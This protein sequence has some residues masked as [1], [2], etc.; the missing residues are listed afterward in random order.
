VESQKFAAKFLS[1]TGTPAPR[2]AGSSTPFA[3][4][5]SLRMTVH[6]CYELQTH[7]TR[8][9]S[10]KFIEEQPQILRLTTPELKTFGAPF[11]QDD[12]RCF[13]MNVRGAVIFGCSSLTRVM[14]L[15]MTT[16]YCCELLGH[17]TRCS[18]LSAFRGLWLG[19][20]RLCWGRG[21]PRLPL[22]GVGPLELRG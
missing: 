10:Q 21:Y 1:V 17:N 16:R 14:M 3:S 12:R 4:L 19:S 9:L 8:G 20:R 11:A 5:R 7:D 22:P 18:W 15:R 6:L 13:S 2:D